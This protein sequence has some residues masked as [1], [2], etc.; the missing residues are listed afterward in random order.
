MMITFFKID[1]RGLIHY[2]SISNR[3]GHLFS[4]YTFTAS[5]GVALS[6]G[7]EKQFVF[8]SQDELDRKL[9]D[10]IASRI[11]HGYRVLY[12]YFRYG[13]DHSLQPVLRRAAAS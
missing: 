3:Q 13:E 8:D 1:A 7:R 6:A 10:L 4:P 5:W 2:Y 9:R 12:S 11:R